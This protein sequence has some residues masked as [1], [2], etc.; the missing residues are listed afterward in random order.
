MPPGR[1]GRTVR[2]RLLVAVALVATGLVACA[3]EIA[4]APLPI[5]SAVTTTPAPAT[6]TALPSPTT[7]AAPPQPP[8]PP[9]IRR[10]SSA[11]P[12]TEP[13]RESSCYGQV[14][15]ELK[16]AETEFAVLGPLCFSTGAVLRLQG[17]GPGLVTVD[18]ESLVAQSYEAGVNDIT[19]LRP[20]TV[21]VT[22]PHDER[23]DTVTVVVVS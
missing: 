12:T 13:T 16:V 5:E 1:R 3:D 9:R 19:F 18:P 8:R 22:I 2:R 23:I 21:E 15:Y 4:V 6:R 10:S 14:V 20:G 7:T 11:P 17:I